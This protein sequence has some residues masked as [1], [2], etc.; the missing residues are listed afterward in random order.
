MDMTVEQSGCYRLVVLRVTKKDCIGRMAVG[1][2]V[3]RVK[4]GIYYVLPQSNAS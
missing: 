2:H 4:V 3:V 1:N